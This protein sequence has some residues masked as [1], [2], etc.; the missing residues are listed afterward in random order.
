[1]VLLISLA[2]HTGQNPCSH[3]MEPGYRDEAELGLLQWR[4]LVGEVWWSCI[5]GCWQR[6][7]RCFLS[8]WQNEEFDLVWFLLT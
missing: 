3:G 1:M 6:D 5:A 4:L 7:E 8:F 2:E